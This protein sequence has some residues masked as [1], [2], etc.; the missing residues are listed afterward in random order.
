MRLQLGLSKGELR[1]SCWLVVAHDCAGCCVR[2]AR[3]SELQ[4]CAEAKYLIYT[5]CSSGTNECLC[6]APVAMLEPLTQRLCYLGVLGSPNKISAHITD[7]RDDQHVYLCVCMH[8]CG[9]DAAALGLTGLGSPQQ[10]HTPELDKPSNTVTETMV[11]HHRGGWSR[12][13]GCGVCTNKCR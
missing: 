1:R 8:A 12:V 4:L 13:Q 5:N 9:I 10:V 6:S 7:I 11:Q 2:Q 3:L